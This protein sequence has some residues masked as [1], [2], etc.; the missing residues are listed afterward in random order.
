MIE[1]PL[2]QEI[3]V[4]LKREATIEARQQDIMDILE[5]R[6]GPA[7]RE[8]AVELTAVEFDRLRDLL[9]FAA[10]CRSLASFRKRLLS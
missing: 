6:F 9:V 2:Y 10:K 5:G 3:A 8:L 4:Q 1:S 7:L